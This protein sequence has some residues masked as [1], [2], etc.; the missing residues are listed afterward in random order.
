[1]KVLY[2]GQFTQGTTSRMRGETLERVLNPALFKVIDTNIPFY[3]TNKL[4]RSFGFRYKFGPLIDKINKFIEESATGAF[5]LIWVDKAV[6]VTDSITEKLRSLAKTLVHYTPDT[7]FLENRSRHFY[8][9]IK[10]YD[11]LITTK[12]FEEEAYLKYVKKDK[13]LYITQGFDKRVHLPRNSF[14]EKQDSIV[15]IGLNEPS[16][17]HV[18]DRL[19]EEGIRV[20]LAGKNWGK[21][22][23]QNPSENLEFLGESLYKDAYA[24]TI[25]RAYF[26]LGLVSKRFP[27]LHTT[28]TFEIPACG[29]L[30]LTER[31]IETLSIFNEEEALFFSDLDELV[32]K[33]KYYLNNIK[34]LKEKTEN[35]FNKVTNMGY[36][37]ESQLKDLCK[38]M[39]LCH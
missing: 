12:S 21:Y 29:T 26:G 14:E 4:V 25:S 35:G 38:T 13:L 16:R 39:G 28:R 8:R 19:L 36:D 7:A 5:D 24:Q 31:N 20:Q 2:I 23:G 33:V 17:E 34:D 37:Y 27:E 30:L 15:F 6:F 10:Y 11:F 3:Q 18:L 1:M 32:N 9:S 22:I